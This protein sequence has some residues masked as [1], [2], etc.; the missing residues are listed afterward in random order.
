M[1]ATGRH[2]HYRWIS[3]VRAAELLGVSIRDVYRL[4]D[5]GQLP[6]YRIAREIRLRAH[7]VE[8]FRT[9]LPRRGRSP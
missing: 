5:Q 6:A 7:E 8:A 3:S 1:A 2:P 9:R 4:I